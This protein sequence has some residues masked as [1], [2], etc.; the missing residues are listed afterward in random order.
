MTTTVN[1]CIWCK[2]PPGM[3]IETTDSN[4]DFCDVVFSCR[5]RDWFTENGK[6]EYSDWSFGAEK[7]D[8]SVADLAENWNE[9]NPLNWECPVEPCKFCGQQPDIE[10]LIRFDSY[11]VHCKTCTVGVIQVG[12]NGAVDRWNQQK[13]LY[14]AKGN[15]NN[16]I[17]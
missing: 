6:L 5:C 10:K 15:Q 9:S 1:N 14:N 13:W 7:G 2:R 4:G 8:E 16:G 3:D 17:E 12:R 11:H